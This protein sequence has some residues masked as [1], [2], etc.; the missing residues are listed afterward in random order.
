[1]TSAVQADESKLHSL[2]I[3]WSKNS[4]THRTAHKY[5]FWVTTTFPRNL[6]KSFLRQSE[7]F[8]EG[9]QLVSEKSSCRHNKKRRQHD[10]VLEEVMKHVKSIKTARNEHR[11]GILWQILDDQSWREAIETFGAVHG[12]GHRRHVLNATHC[13]VLIMSSNV[14]HARDPFTQRPQQTHQPCS[15][16]QQR[17]GD[18]VSTKRKMRYVKNGMK[19]AGL[20]QSFQLF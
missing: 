14:I 13:L 1:M 5:Q 19:I 9:L 15:Q 10:L 20:E 3:P 4:R 11:P 7:P 16:Q 6:S 18:R 2:E 12:T 8:T 17:K